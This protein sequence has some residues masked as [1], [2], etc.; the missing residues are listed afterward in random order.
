MT[1]R[2]KFSMKSHAKA[3]ED[4]L[5]IEEIEERVREDVD[6]HTPDDMAPTDMSFH[7]I[8]DEGGESGWYVT[9]S[10]EEDDVLMVYP[11][12]FQEVALEETPFAD[13][14]EFQGKTVMFPFPDYDE[15]VMN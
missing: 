11:V 8:P 7:T 12:R 10:E 2:V 4:G 15:E 5:T 13:V 6:S 1:Y 14:P 3:V 9:P